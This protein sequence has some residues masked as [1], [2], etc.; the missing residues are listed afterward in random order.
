MKR[1]TPFVKN[2]VLWLCLALTS[3]SGAPLNAQKTGAVLEVQCEGK[4]GAMS[5]G[6]T[7]EVRHNTITGGYYFLATDLRDIP[8]IGVI[9]D[10]EIKL[11]TADG[12]TFSLRFEG[13]G[14]EHG[15]RLD[16]DNSVALVGT[17]HDKERVE[18]V[19]LGFLTMG[20]PIH[21]RRYAFATNLSD[22]AFEA[23]IRKWRIA[24]LAGNRRVAAEYTH[25]PLRVNTHRTYIMIRTPAELY[26]RW[27]RIFT[28]AYLSRIRQDLP[29]DMLGDS[30]SLLVGLGNGDVWF[31]DKGVEVL[32]LPD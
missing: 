6:M 21:G 22:A 31:G 12:S 2:R 7:L 26:K 19:D 25:F 29:H 3:L 13:N 14:S 23:I 30:A 32:N 5:A 11:S 8:I 18:R 9:R 10:G 27:D 24:V 15:E 17:H 1:L 4:I 20:A 28:V 16:F